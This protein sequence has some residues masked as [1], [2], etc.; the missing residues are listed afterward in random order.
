[1]GCES[2]RVGRYE[3]RLYKEA[4]SDGCMAVNMMTRFRRAVPC[5]FSCSFMWCIVSC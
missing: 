1:M 5:R 4:L 2:L 3:Q